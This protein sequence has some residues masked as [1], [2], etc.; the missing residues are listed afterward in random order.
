MPSSSSEAALTPPGN[1]A[2]EI[3]HPVAV[4]AQHEV[5]G[6]GRCDRPSDRGSLR[7]CGGGVAL[8]QLAVAGVDV[9]APA[10]LGIGDLE[11]ADVRK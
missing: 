5:V 1:E 7:G 3:D 6:A 4:G 10:G 11:Q 8:A 9:A 2:N